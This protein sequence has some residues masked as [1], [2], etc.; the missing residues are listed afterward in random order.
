MQTAEGKHIVAWNMGANESYLIGKGHLQ[1]EEHIFFFF[2][3]AFYL[4]N[5]QNHNKQP[6]CLQSWDVRNGARAGGDM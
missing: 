5:P 3:R 4:Y 6:D 2:L 1:K